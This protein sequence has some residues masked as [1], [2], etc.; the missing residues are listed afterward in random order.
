MRLLVALLLGWALATRAHAG[1]ETSQLRNGVQARVWSPWP[2]QI[3]RG[4][5][6]IYVELENHSAQ[7]QRLRLS[8]SCNDWLERELDTGLELGPGEKAA[9]ELLVPLGAQYSNEYS[10][11]LQA[12]GESTWFGSA[13]GS[14]AADPS[15]HPVLYVSE[16][17]P[18]A[19]EVERWSASL[20]TTHVEARYVR[21]SST[22]SASEPNDVG[23]AHAT[24]AGLAQHHAAYSSL[25]LVV[26]DAALGL[27]GEERL[28]ALLAW[29]RTGGDLLLVGARAHQAALGVPALAAWMEPR[30]ETKHDDASEYRCGLGRLYVGEFAPG[31]EGA[32]AERVR[33]IVNDNA[34]LVPKAGEWRGAQVTPLIPNLVRLPYRTFALLLFLFALVIGPLNFFVVWKKKRPVLVLLTIP[35][36]ALLT[37]VALLVYGVLFQGLDVKTASFSVAVLDQRAHRSAC[38][39]AR[40]MFAGL[41]PAAGLALGAGTSVHYQPR[42]FGTGGSR[43]H[44][45]IE[46]D[47]GT[48]LSGD[49]LPSRRSVNQVLS[50][51]RAERARLSTRLGAEG[52]EVGNDLGARVEELI[53]RAADGRFYLAAAPLAPGESVV[54][55]ALDDALAADFA[56]HHLFSASLAPAPA[57]A[58]EAAAD[59]PPGCYLAR[60]AASP[61]RDACGI[62]T[63]ELAGAHVVLGVLS[64]DAEDWR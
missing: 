58:K 29:V 56:V 60:L 64:L 24:F 7:R 2:T 35:G 13:V 11:Q 51:E 39:E 43:A 23:L 14:Y 57:E 34:S 44:Y 6:P 49:Y 52:L 38:V 20:S 10:V 19:G 25:D 63:N 32:C 45:S 4:W 54:L 37:T 18:A 42:D 41:A 17:V 46:L 62:E 40:Q 21:S 61:F 48:L 59:L 53:V 36:L 55:R 15:L 12:N 3:Y 33:Q 31:F 47:G 5:A 26:L 30:F 16:S 8:A 50:V 27:P 9:L 1:D 22:G 28:A